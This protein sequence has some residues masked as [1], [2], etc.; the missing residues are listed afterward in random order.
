MKKLYTSPTVTVEELAKVD[1]LSTSTE[2]NKTNSFGGAKR[3]N[4]NQM[5][6]T[7]SDMSGLL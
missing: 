3:D 2:Q 4:I 6:R 7:I 1:V 5:A